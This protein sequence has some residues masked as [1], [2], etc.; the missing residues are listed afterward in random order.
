[1]L[2]LDYIDSLKEAFNRYIGRDG[3]AYVERKKITPVEAVQL[4]S[5]AKGFPVLAH[6]F[7]VGD[8]ENLIVEL[9]EAGLIGIEAHYDSYAAHEVAKLV[10]LADKYGLITTGGSDYH[11]LDE[12]TETALGGVDVPVAVAERLIALAES[13]K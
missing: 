11:G 3:S 6:P 4:V 2:E 12:N 7:T 8:P 10:A 9:K 1:M 13:R 5:R